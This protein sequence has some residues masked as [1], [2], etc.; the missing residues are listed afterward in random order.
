MDI[1]FGCGKK[2]NPKDKNKYNADTS[3]LKRLGVEKVPNSGWHWFTSTEGER[4]RM[5]PICEK[6]HT[7]LD[8]I[9][10][11]AKRTVKGKITTKKN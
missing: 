6:C 1:C 10:K 5:Y 2:L 8:S 9:L 7:K 3:C 11:P 4:I